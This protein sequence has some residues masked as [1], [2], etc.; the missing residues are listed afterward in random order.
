MLPKHV[1]V[2]VQALASQAVTAPDGVSRVLVSELS[3][4]D[5]KALQEAAQSLLE[6]LGGQAVVLLASKGD[7]NKVSFVA[8]V[9]QQVRQAVGVGGG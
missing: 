3:G 7:G 2:P 6:Q 4:L 1:L 5:P 8:A 9:S